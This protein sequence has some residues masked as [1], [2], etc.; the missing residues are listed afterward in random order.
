MCFF[1]GALLYIVSTSFIGLLSNC[2]VQCIQLTLTKWE[3][4]LGA[5]ITDKKKN[6]VLQLTHLSSLASSMAE[7]NFKLLT[8]WQ[9]HLLNFPTNS[10]LCWRNCGKNSTHA[11]VWWSC[12]LILTF[13]FE[14]IDLIHQITK[15]N[16]SFDPWTVLFHVTSTPIGRYKH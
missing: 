7:T 8:R 2:R 10:S 11:H 6:K 1:V 13:W 9:L 4:Y 5:T 14:V 16:I 15:V 3:L 12:P